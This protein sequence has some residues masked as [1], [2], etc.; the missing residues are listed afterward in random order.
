[1]TQSGSNLKE[2]EKASEHGRILISE[3]CDSLEGYLNREQIR[4]V[5]RAY[6]FS[7][8]AHQHQRRI[9]GE[10]YIYHPISVAHILAGMRMDHTCL[11]AAILHDVIEDTGTSKEVVAREFGEEVAELVDGVSKLT[12]MNFGSQAEAQ[13]ANFRK[14]LL[15]VAKDI[16]VIIIKLADRLHNM[17]TLGVMRP[18]KRRRIAKETLEIYAPIA[19]RFGIN[20]I[21][22]ELELLGFQAY[23]P[24]RYRVITER[25]KKIRG[26]RKETIG[27]IEEAIRLR[28]GQEG[29]EAEVYGRKKNPYSIYRKMQGK[30]LPLSEL[31]DVYAFRIIVDKIDTCYRALGAVHNLYKPKPGAFKD[32]IAIPKA[33]GYQSLHTVLIALHGLPIEIQIRTQDMHQI[34]ESGIA[35]HWNYKNRHAGR[36]PLAHGAS[37]WLSSLLEMQ[38]GVG[39]SME[40]LENVKIDLYP[41]EVY[42]FT[43]RG[44]IMVLAKG[45]TVID[46]AYAVHTDVGSRCVAARVDRRLAPL[47][48]RLL[49]GQTVEI[50]TREGAVPNPAWLNFVVTSKARGHIRSYLKNLKH[51]EAAE[52]GRR[53]L[54]KE[55]TAYDTCIEA[56]PAER[57]ATV[58]KE[59]GA[60]SLQGL[61]VEI[62]LGNRMPLLVAQRL[63]GLEGGPLPEASHRDRYEGPLFIRGTEGMVV[64]YAKCCRPIPGD[65][66]TA[67]FNPGKGMVVHRQECRNLK[68]ERRSGETWLELDWEKVIEAS[69][70]TE[71]R[72][73]VGNQRGVLASV[74]A[75]IADMGS[76]ID[77]VGIE[78][79]DGLTSTL[80]FVIE[81]T[82]R[83]HLARIM[84]RLR[85]LPR[86]IRIVRGLS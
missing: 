18:E 57:V 52:L 11:M 36:D 86:V 14:M 22:L 8:E 80:I 46:F 65:Q 79:R 29:I 76:N 77:N 35:A 48:S 39:D 49:T 62:G 13:A 73:S 31:A 5:Y 59:C 42:V 38:S 70:A 27:R 1:M 71:I 3:F 16:R 25:S 83:Q 20:S 26:N 15:A 60:G 64:N 43:P 82:D 61:L 69:F 9:S 44:Q 17:R 56:I 51:Q 72:V 4:E 67:V 12:Q 66:I 45:A 68:K 55:L 75:A 30:R 84:R 21:R 74:A 19:N 24:A 78:E 28:L 85:S 34:A 40:F 53:L 81:V 50:I 33:N 58:L 41:D 10:P 7:A 2:A 23:W 63:T 6:L 32:Y 37:E 54:E 47:R